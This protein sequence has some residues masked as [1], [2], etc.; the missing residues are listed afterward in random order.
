MIHQDNAS[1][2]KYHIFNIPTWVSRHNKPMK[3]IIKHLKAQN[4]QQTNQGTTQQVEAHYEDLNINPLFAY[5]QQPHVL[6]YRV[7]RFQCV[8]HNKNSRTPKT[9][10]TL[11]L[12][13]IHC[14][15][16][17]WTHYCFC[18]HCCT[19]WLLNTLLHTLLNTLLLP[20]EKTILF[21]THFPNVQSLCNL[22]S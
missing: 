12:E 8:I 4:V 2:T 18:K 15:T 7:C 9:R 11:G 20:N 16:H 5:F 10:F 1:I 17:C 22:V 6:Y 21:L 14:C 19:H 3:I 13:C